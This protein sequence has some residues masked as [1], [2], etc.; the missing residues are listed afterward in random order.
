MNTIGIIG[1]GSMGGMLARGFV[2]AGACKAE[3]LHISSRS[4]AS[5]DRAAAE[6]PGATVAA[7]NAAVAAAADILFLCVKPMEVRPVLGALL[8]ALRAETHLVSLAAGVT[9]DYLAGLRAGANSKCIPSVTSEVRDGIA[10]LC[11]TGPVSAAQRQE[12]ERLLGSIATV[13]VVA[14]RHMSICSNLTSCAPGLLAA[15][16]D[17]YLQAALRISD[18]DP[19]EAELMLNVTLRGLARLLIEKRLTFAQAIERVATKGGITEQGVQVLRRGLPAVFDETHAV[20]MT[21]RQEMR[22]ALDRG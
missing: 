9:L 12:C 8:P 13:A 14:E 22:A 7:D 6:V 10:L 19:Q 21:K 16:A 4:A 18:L 17:E 20:T 3:Q 11:H 15:I 1:Y 5:R 2:A